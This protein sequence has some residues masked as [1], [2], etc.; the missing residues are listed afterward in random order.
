MQEYSVLLVHLCSFYFE[1]HPAGVRGLGQAC[2][3]LTVLWDIGLMVE[4]T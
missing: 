1:G 2:L 4:D 3:V